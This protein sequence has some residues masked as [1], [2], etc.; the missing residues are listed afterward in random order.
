MTRPLNRRRIS[1]VVGAIGPPLQAWCQGLLA[2]AVPD[3]GAGHRERQRKHG[4]D[5]VPVPAGPLPTFRHL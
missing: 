4:Q 2:R 1:A 3:G 5:D